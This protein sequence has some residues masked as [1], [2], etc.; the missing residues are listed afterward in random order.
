V[1]SL[2][3]GLERFGDVQAPGTPS[4]GTPQGDVQARP[5]SA[6]VSRPEISL[7]ERIRQLRILRLQVQ[8]A[9]R[10]FLDRAGVFEQLARRNG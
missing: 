1:Q 9:K 10:Q 4:R 6:G 3:S 2:V 7:E 5:D 8:E